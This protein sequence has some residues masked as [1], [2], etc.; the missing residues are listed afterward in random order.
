[1]TN[2]VVSGRGGLCPYRLV[3]CLAVQLSKDFDDS[4]RQRVHWLG[5]ILGM[6]STVMSP[7]T[8][9]MHASL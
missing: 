2:D 5:R 1:M 7:Y 6:S 9:V 8:L 3:W 4:T